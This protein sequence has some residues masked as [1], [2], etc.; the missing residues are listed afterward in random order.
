MLRSRINWTPLHDFSQ[1]ANLIDQAFSAAG[2]HNTDR[3]AVPVD[4]LEMDGK[5][6][7]RAAMPGVR[8]ENV[9]VTIESNVLTIS[10][11]YKSTSEESNAKVYRLENRYGSFTRSLKLPT[12]LQ[13]DKV[14]A[15]FE[16]GI[17]TITIPRVEPI[18][19]ETLK[20]PVQRS[21]SASALTVS[22]SENSERE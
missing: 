12:D 3:H 1:V 2:D 13:L 7:F 11:E 5:L 10:G 17:V 6:I 21:E 19:P 15:S 20:V 4:I 22:E 9:D 16:D 8:A 14:N 18:K